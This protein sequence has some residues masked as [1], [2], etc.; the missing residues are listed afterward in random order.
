VRIPLKII[1]AYCFFSKLEQS[2]LLNT[3]IAAANAHANVLCVHP[4]S[5]QP[6]PMLGEDESKPI[7]L[8]IV[9]LYG[10]FETRE[11]FVMEMELMQSLD[12][13]EKL[14]EVG[15][16]AEEQVMACNTIIILSLKTRCAIVFCVINS[17][18]IIY[19]CYRRNTLPYNWCR[20]W[21]CVRY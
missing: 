12:L 2:H 17:S 8:P 11:H 4:T 18:N 10:I 9:Q 21:H 5:P 16:F 13:S 15:E 20:R 6:S 14:N 1:H 3:I 7:E 19:I